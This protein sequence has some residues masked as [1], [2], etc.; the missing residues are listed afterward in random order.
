MALL[1]EQRYIIWNGD[2]SSLEET[3]KRVDAAL[4][5]IPEK[6]HED[7]LSLSNL[8]M[9]LGAAHYRNQVRMMVNGE[10]FAFLIKGEK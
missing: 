5:E 9:D 4:A 10:A 7:I 6:Y 1:N 2:E 8:F 3:N